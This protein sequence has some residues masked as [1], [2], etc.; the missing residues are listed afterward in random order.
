MQININLDKRDWQKF[1]DHIGKELSKNTKTLSST[2]WAN[3]SVWVLLVAI[4]I[5]LLN[6]IDNF[7]WQTAL[8]V[9]IFFICIFTVFILTLMQMKKAFEPGD[10]GIFCGEHEFVF[11][12]QGISSKGSGYTAKHS[13]SIVKR[14]ERVSGMILIYFDTAYAFVFNET[15]LADPDAFYKAISEFY[16]N[17]RME[18]SL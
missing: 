7:D 17:N 3:I 13:W 14:I 9:S 4:F 12:E 2:S 5:V 16:S 10:R 8:V 15:K 11:D 18:N 1:Q 6:Y